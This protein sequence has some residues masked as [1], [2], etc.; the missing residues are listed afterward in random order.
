[1]T[2]RI[3]KNSSEKFVTEDSFDGTNYFWIKPKT[4]VNGKGRLRI[5]NMIFGI[6]NTFTNE[7]VMGCSMKEYVS[8]ISESIPSMD[9][10][11]KVDNQDL[12]YS[13]DNPE[14]AIAYMEIGQVEFLIQNQCMVK[15]KNCILN[16]RHSLDNI[17]K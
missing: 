12:Y 14:S 6:A 13:V 7:K 8:P 1:M 17:L 9:V 10:S 15:K 3:Y 11:I 2:T 4:M 5:G 16:H